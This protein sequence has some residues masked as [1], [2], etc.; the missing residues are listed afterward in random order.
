MVIPKCKCT[1]ASDNYGSLLILCRQQI[2]QALSVRNTLITTTTAI[3]LLIS[4]CPTHQDLQIRYIHEAL[5]HTNPF[6]GWWCIYF[7]K[8]WFIF[9]NYFIYLTLTSFGLNCPAQI[10][11]IM[12][13]NQSVSRM[14]IQ[15]KQRAHTHTNTHYNNTHC[16]AYSCDWR[17]CPHK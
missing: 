13:T 6:T 7:L 3:M 17:P 16:H 2:T 10:M 4:R 15:M 9:K 12:K 8:F 5:R 1:Q 14:H 11:T